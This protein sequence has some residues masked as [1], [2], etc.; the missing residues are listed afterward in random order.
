MNIPCAM[1]TRYAR[2]LAER[3]GH[4]LQSLASDLVEQHRQVTVLKENA[5]LRAELGTL[6]GKP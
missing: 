5:K 1:A 6:R 2:W 3:L 4:A